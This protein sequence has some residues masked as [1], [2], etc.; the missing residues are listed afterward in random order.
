MIQYFVINFRFFD[1]KKYI[2]IFIFDC[3]YKTFREIT[4]FYFKNQ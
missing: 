1:I 2:F 3:N 4:D